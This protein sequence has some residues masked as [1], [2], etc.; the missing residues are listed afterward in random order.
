MTT[1]K[2]NKSFIPRHAKS[3]PG[4]E[5]TM[6]RDTEGDVTVSFSDGS[7]DLRV[8]RRDFMRISGVAAA[9]AA[10]AGAGCDAMR[11]PVERIVPY[12]DRPEET[13]IGKFSTYATV[14]NSVGVLVRTRVGRPVK[15]EGNPNHPT[16]LG[17]LSARGQS[18]YMSLY[19]PDRAQAPML[20]K[21]K[22]DTA[23]VKTWDTIDNEIVNHLKKAG[24]SVRLGILTETST[25]SAQAALIAE[26]LGQLQNAKH[27]TYEPTNDEAILLANEA[28]Y[29]E[30]TIPHYR[31][32][33]ADMVVSLQSDFLGDWLSPV[34]FTKQFSKRR[35]P[36]GKMS[37]LVAFEGMLTLTGANADDRYKVRPSD[38]AHVCMALA[39]EVIVT[40]KAGPLA[41]NGQ[42]KSSVTAFT[43]DAVSKRT[44]VDAAVLKAVGAELAKHVNGAIVVAGGIASST[45]NGVELEAAVNLLNAALGADGHTIERDTVTRQSQGQLSQLKAL[46]D[47]INSGKIDAL[48]VAGPNP[49]YSAPA[50]L[51]LEAALKNIPFFV[52]CNDRIDETSAYANFLATGSHFLES[53][54]DALPFA[55][56]YSLQ[57]PVIRPLYATRSF[58]ASLITWLS[59]SELIPSLK[60]FLEEGTEPGG[61]QAGN[62]DFKTGPW[63]RYLR[64]HWEKEVYPKAKAV[65]GF[66]AFWEAVLRKGIWVSPEAARTAPTFNVAKNAALLPKQVGEAAKRG[67]LGSKEIVLFS[68]IPLGDGRY[69]NNGHLLELPDPIT[70]ST[71]DSYVMVGSK[72]FRDEGLQNGQFLKIRPAGSDKELEFPVI[73]VPGMHEDVVAVPLGWGRTKA[74]EVANGLGENAFAF[75][76]VS[77]QGTQVLAGIEVG[78]TKT[79]KVETPAIP[80]GSQVID[81]HKRTFIA[82]T[83]LAEYQK[84]QSAGIHKHP[85]LKDFWEDHQYS[86]KWGMSVD[87]SKCTGCGACVIAC[88]EENNTPVVGRQGITEGREMHWMRIDRYYKLPH[89][90]ELEHRRESA[91]TDPMFAEEPYVEMSEYLDEPR[92]VF[93]PIMCQHCE[94]APCETVCPVLATMHSSDGLNQMAYNRC[95]GTRY[96]ANNCPFKVRRF[97]WYNYSENRSEEFFARL[98]PELKLHGTYNNRHP[99]HMAFNPEVT[100]RSRGVMEKCTF[101]VQRIRRGKWQMKKEG[102]DK[103]IDGD[104]VTACQQTCP[105]DAIT[106]GNLIDPNSAVSKMHAKASALSPLGEIGVE[107]SVAYLTKVINGEKVDPMG[108]AH[109]GGG[110]GGHD[111]GHGD[112]KAGHSDHH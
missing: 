87:L 107:S 61:N 105:A 20:L 45:E 110:H 27:Y 103:I 64:A 109:H 15:L 5:I 73:M 92:V 38:L 3:D 74:G 31:F 86:L 96:C 26:V 79:D 57:Q 14:W 19:D 75:S 30:R 83:T 76:T 18:S 25:G 101:C 67:G 40:A 54:G 82:T 80:Q 71:W 52:S 95:V 12:V 41:S 29:G 66:E 62:A 55:G 102:R 56:Q 90:E 16:S 85:P 35:D 1:S 94:N 108:Q 21:G 91:F 36:N 84:D 50:E 68:S 32:D 4:A 70:R 33:K 51:G 53:W 48:V 24:K 23:E 111:E 89:N 97:N 46:I 10:A 72:T 9:A 106:F 42:A 7:E 99:L 39:H 63:Y 6:R 58:E 78:L 112:E 43:A 17:G 77:K 37:R 59:K 69:A 8:S 93:Q 28:A 65:S 60:T 100:V 81:L 104:V 34:E 44:G 2:R 88:Q 49:V 47:D 22:G 13:R 11:N 98:Y